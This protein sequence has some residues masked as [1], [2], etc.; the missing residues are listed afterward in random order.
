MGL[1]VGLA[2]TLNERPRAHVGGG[3]SFSNALIF[4]DGAVIPLADESHLEILL[5]PPAGAV[6]SGCPRLAR[7]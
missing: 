2:A 7:L 4:C 1:G 5:G 6:A 3:G